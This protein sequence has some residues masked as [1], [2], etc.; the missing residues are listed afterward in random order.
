[1]SNRKGKTQDNNDMN[2]ALALDEGSPCTGE[3]DPFET[4]GIFSTHFINEQKT[5]LLATVPRESVQAAYE[6]IKAIYQS[7]LTSQRS[8]QSKHSDKKG[9]SESQTETD[10]FDKV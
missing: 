1:M 7:V 4:H 5:E 9:L 6:S 3:G 2:G 10:L 8:I